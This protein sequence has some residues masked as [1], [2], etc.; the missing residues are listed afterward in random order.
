MVLQYAC[1]PEGEGGGKDGRLITVRYREEMCLR[2]SQCLSRTLLTSQEMLASCSC[3]IYGNIYLTSNCSGKQEIIK[4]YIQMFSI[5]CCGFVFL[6]HLSSFTSVLSVY[7]IYTI[8]IYN[9]Y[10]CYLADLEG[11]LKLLLDD[12]PLQ[13]TF[14]ACDRKI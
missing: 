8:Y 5:S 7:S 11:V 2:T 10:M 1:K 13:I 6:S 14:F 4:E 3:V 12:I 9:I